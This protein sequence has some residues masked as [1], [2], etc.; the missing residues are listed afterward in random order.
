MEIKKVRDRSNL[1][2]RPRNAAGRTF[3]FPELIPF[4]RVKRRF[5]SV[6]FDFDGTL[7]D[8][9]WVW[10]Q[11]DDRFC[12]KYD[13]VLPP[14]YYET[15]TALTFEG[16]AKFFHE[17]FGLAMSTEEIA[18][19]FNALAYE[20]YARDVLC[21]TGAIQY[22]ETLRDRGVS[23]AIA[24]S[25]P[26]SLLE[27]A[28]ENNHIAGLFDDIAFC[29]ESAA[30]SKPDVYLLA[31]ER[32]GADPADCLLFEDLATGIRSA[33]SVGM[34]TCAVLGPY[35][36]QDEDEMTTVADFH[37]ESYEQLLLGC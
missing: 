15:I 25:L 26:W 17:E 31:A 28:I 21:K 37:I 32:L 18:H 10:E 2:T 33:R 14:G 4:D 8:S 20:S 29:D 36:H 1:K 12:E 19:E 7:A 35:R 9:M 30:K 16:T 5:S 27:A 6:I 13:L 22:L 24:T 34:T 3:D 23:L 11:I